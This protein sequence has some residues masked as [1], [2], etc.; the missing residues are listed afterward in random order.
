MSLDVEQRVRERAYAIWLEQGCPEGRDGDHWLQ[1]ER[2]IRLP[3]EPGIA[4]QAELSTSPAPEV[5]APRKTARKTK[6]EPAA[7][8]PTSDQTPKPR[9][10]RTRSKTVP[11]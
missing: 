11:A 1:A 4:A 10:P 8:T 2:D 9:K 5:K 7:V 6:A 3:A